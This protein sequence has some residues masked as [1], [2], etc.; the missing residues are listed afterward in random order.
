MAQSN[1]VDFFN[2]PAQNKLIEEDLHHATKEIIQSGVVI[3]GDY[4]NRLEE[5]LAT[6]TGFKHAILV[7]SGTDALT[8]AG[9][10]WLCAEDGSPANLNTLNTIK[11]PAFSFR[12]TANAFLNTSNPVKFFFVDVGPNGTA[13][14]TQPENNSDGKKVRI[15]LSVSVGMFGQ[16]ANWGVGSDIHDG[17]QSW[18][19]ISSLAR[20]GCDVTVSFDPTKNLS[21]MGNGGAI[22][23]N[24]DKRAHTL[25]SIRAN[26]PYGMNSRMSEIDAAVVLAK[27]RY[28]KQWQDRRAKIAEYLI[29]NLPEEFTP[30]ITKDDIIRGAHALQKFPVFINSLE[31][32]LVFLDLHKANIETKIHYDYVLP[33][34]F[35]S[36]VVPDTWS[37]FNSFTSTATVLSQRLISLPFY[38]ELTDSQVEYMVATLK[39][40]SK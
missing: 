27:T 32:S 22:L 15:D 9:R 5:W 29:D 37:F 6:Y 40:I 35:K 1:K 20:E 3:G 28:I 33:E 14:L 24:S 19:A 38:P 10:Y 8:I 7:G 2:L 16:A 18:L 31:R 34:V 12:A 36:V 23:T 17:A 4:S 39:S 11:L 13:D 21:A 25:K 26:G 30:I